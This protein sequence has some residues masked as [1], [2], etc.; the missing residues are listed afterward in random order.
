MITLNIRNWV[1]L[2]RKELM[3]ILLA[4][5]RQ[6]HNLWQSYRI[7]S[8]AHMIKFNKAKVWL[9]DKSAIFETFIKNSKCSTQIL[10][11]NSHKTKSILIWDA[12]R[13]IWSKTSKRSTKFSKLNSSKL[14]TVSRPVDK[15]LFMNSFI[16]QFWCSKWYQRIS[17]SLKSRRK[18]K[19]LW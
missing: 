19:T 12:H 9:M 14:K 11:L 6:L 8:K 2:S 15:L 4:R 16:I 10:N 17:W 3:K 18:I 7:T 13:T 5:R 1:T